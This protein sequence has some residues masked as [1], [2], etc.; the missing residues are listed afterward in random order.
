M[1]DCFSLDLIVFG[2]PNHSIIL[3]SDDVQ[4][5]FQVNNYLFHVNIFNTMNLTFNFAVHCFRISCL[6]RLSTAISWV[7][8]F[9]VWMLLFL[10]ELI[11]FMVFFLRK[12]FKFLWRFLFWFLRRIWCWLMLGVLFTRYLFFF[13]RFN[14][15]IL[16]SWF[17]AFSY[18]KIFA[19]AQSLDAILSQDPNQIV[20]LL[21]YIRYNFLPGIQQCS[22]KIMTIMR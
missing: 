6:A 21:E 2:W 1:G 12:W 7:F 15:S 3:E 22:I 5:A 20:T 11:K 13:Y 10:I 16:F 9:Q 14:Y 4:I 17:Q 18:S 19:S 8:L